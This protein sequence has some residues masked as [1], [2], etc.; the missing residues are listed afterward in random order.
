[1]T[2]ENRY[3]AL[4]LIMVTATRYLKNAAGGNKFKKPV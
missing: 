2:L 1:M 3:A 4:T